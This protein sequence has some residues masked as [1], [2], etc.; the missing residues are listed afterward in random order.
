MSSN[1]TI[2]AFAFSLLTA[3]CF[4]VGAHA[5][6]AAPAAAA[7]SSPAKDTSVVVKN[8]PAAPSNNKSCEN[9]KAEIDGK[10]KAKG[11]KAFTL[12]VVPAADVK[13]EKVIGSCE[14]GAKKIT[15][16]RG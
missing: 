13:T 5:E 6:N 10:L 12:E 8:A 3:S 16:K 4:A 11:V 14:A 15:Y 1:R 2:A 9:L 7:A